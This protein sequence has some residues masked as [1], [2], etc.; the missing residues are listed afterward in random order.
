MIDE[1][2]EFWSQVLE[3]ESIREKSIVE[4]VDKLHFDCAAILGEL[5]AALERLSVLGS[6]NGRPG[7]SALDE[8]QNE[9]ESLRIKHSAEV[10]KL[11]LQLDQAHRRADSLITPERFEAE[12][13]R[14]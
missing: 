11:S 12:V 10:S 4:R 3:N 8:L 14:L 13:A 1:C 9:I 6:M 5:C 7:E 2:R